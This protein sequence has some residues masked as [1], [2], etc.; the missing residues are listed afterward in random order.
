MLRKS[1]DDNAP[2]SCA[3]VETTLDNP[4]NYYALSYT[5][6]VEAP[7]EAMAV[8]PAGDSATSGTPDQNVLLTPNFVAALNLL[9]RR[10]G[11]SNTGVWVDAVCIN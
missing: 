4:A 10:L 7:S 2:L 6:G 5:W 1:D 3:I 8:S 9:R 11:D